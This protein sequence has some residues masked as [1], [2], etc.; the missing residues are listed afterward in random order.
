MTRALVC[1]PEIPPKAAEGRLDEIRACIGCN[2]ACIGH[3]HAGHPISCIQHPETG[4]ELAYGRRPAA[5]SRRVLV[6]GAGRAA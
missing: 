6:A 3:F 2:Q 5:R 1:D 4:R